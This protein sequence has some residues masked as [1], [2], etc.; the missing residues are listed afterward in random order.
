V[1]RTGGL[2]ESRTR[3]LSEAREKCAGAWDASVHGS[4]VPDAD[5]N[6]RSREVVR[7]GMQGVRAKRAARP[8]VQRNGRRRDAS[9]TNWVAI[10][11]SME[12]LGIN[13]ADRRLYGVNATGAKGS[14]VVAYCVQDGVAENDPYRFVVKQ[15]AH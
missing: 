15:Y 12:G 8:I 14:H 4:T 3:P 13:T 6:A 5:A 10:G 1:F 11:P 9:T 2:H 7:H